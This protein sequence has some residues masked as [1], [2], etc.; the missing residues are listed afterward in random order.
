M[1]TF[2]SP[3]LF[4]CLESQVP[5]VRTVKIGENLRM[6][7]IDVKVNFDENKLT[8]I[9]TSVEEL[10]HFPKTE[11]LRKTGIFRIDGDHGGFS[12]LELVNGSIY[13]RNYL[14][15]GLDEYEL[16]DE[17]VFNQK[18]ARQFIKGFITE[19]MNDRNL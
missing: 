2:P 1:K 12:R 7:T 6:K 14:R 11:K 15:K 17:V 9:E 5:C 16:T 18:Q 4:T 10:F 13:K 8:I 3:S 19:R